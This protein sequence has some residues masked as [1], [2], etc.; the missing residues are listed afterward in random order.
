MSPI[1]KSSTKPRTQIVVPQ[2]LR[3]FI[4]DQLHVKSGHFGIYK[5][6]EKISERFFWPGYEQDIRTAVVKCEQCQRRNQPVPKSQAPLGTIN[7]DYPFQKLS[8]DIMGPLPTSMKGNK[9][10]LV[11]T[12]LFSKWVE[13]FPLVK[14]DSLTLAKVLTDEIVCRYGVPEVMH[15]DKGSNF[16]SEMI[17]SLCDQLGIKRT[18][19]TAYHPQGNGQVERFNRALEGSLSKMVS[20]H[21]RDWDDHLQKV[22]LA[23]RTAVHECTGYTPFMVTFGWSPNL[24]ID[25]ILGKPLSETKNIPDYVKQTRASMRMAIL[26][27]RQR[28]REAH[29]KQKKVSDKRVVEE[30]LHVGDRV[31]LFVPAVKSGTTKKLSSLWRGPYTILDKLSAVN[32][33][34]QLTGG[35]QKQV[36]HKNR[37]K[38]CLSDPEGTE[39]SQPQH[40]IS[41]DRNQ[42]NGGII[43]FEAE[44][45]YDEADLLNEEEGNEEIDAGRGNEREPLVRTENFRRNPERFRR[46]PDHYQAGFS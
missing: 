28:N 24:P 37:L 39:T 9:Y 43:M 30:T 27:V 4:F 23:Y 15:S 8:W 19:T 6:F 16:F 33:R 1:T 11:V 7:A 22:L 17:Q 31:W 38:L 5:T 42:T 13:A 10:T 14:T 20:S 29:W 45:R 18:Q 36:V 3:K 32:Y 25:V 44:E 40:S 12:D 26:E 21:Q 2:S 34:I 35:D 46:P 41:T